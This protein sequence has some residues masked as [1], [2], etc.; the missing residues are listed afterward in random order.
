MGI[1]FTKHAI[2]RLYNRG[3]SQSDAWYTFK[4]PD[5]NLPGKTLGSKKFYKDY[6]KQRI[7]VI[8]KQNKRGQWLILS[9]WSKYK[10]DGKPMFAKKEAFLKAIIKKIL[11]K[12]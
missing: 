6:D 1:V 5:G 7:E 11:G 8:A 2:N 10:G 4:H 3:I 12:I 9:C